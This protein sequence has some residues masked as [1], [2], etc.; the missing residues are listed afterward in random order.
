MDAARNEVEAETVEVEW[1]GQSL[2]IPAS[3]D[4]APIEVMEAFEAGKSVAALRGLLGA[5]EF[6]RLKAAGMTGRDFKELTKA[7]SLALGF[8]DSGK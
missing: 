1:H 2:T 5:T 4:D 3:L 7:C 6:E 8:E